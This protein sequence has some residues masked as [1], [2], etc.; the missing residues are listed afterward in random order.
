MGLWYGTGY[1]SIFIGSGWLLIKTFI[2]GMLAVEARESSVGPRPW[3]SPSI[4]RR[5]SQPGQPA[6]SGALVTSCV[7][8]RLVYLQGN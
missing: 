2:C 8:R 1:S 7:G 6:L 4:G 5:P 3:P